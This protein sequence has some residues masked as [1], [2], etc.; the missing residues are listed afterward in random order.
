MNLAYPPT[1]VTPLPAG[2]TAPVQ[3][4]YQAAQ[5]GVPPGG[6]P[7]YIPPPP[8]NYGQGVGAQ[9]GDDLTVAPVAPVTLGDF[10]VSP[11]TGVAIGGALGLGAAATGVLG[12]LG[13]LASRIKFPWQT[14]AGEGFIAPWQNQQRLPEGLWGIESM[15]Y[16]QAQ[17]PAVAPQ[18][19]AGMTYGQ[20]KG[21][22]PVKAWTNAARNGTSPATVAFVLFSNGMMASQSLIDGQIKTWRPKKH[23]VISRNPRLSNIRKLD[24]AHSRMEKTLR[25]YAKT[26][27][28]TKKE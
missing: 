4:V 13:L 19:L 15:Q 23:I 12:G 16:P 1:P 7:A 6:I 8:T 24:K 5:T 17:V 10:G 3:E 21:G 14:P 2:P 20:L 11:A 22:V 18:G 28:R 9:P 25:P 27:Y 26:I